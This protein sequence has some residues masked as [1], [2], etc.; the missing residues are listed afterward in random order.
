LEEEMAKEELIHER[1]MAE[2][3]QPIRIT[4]PH[5]SEDQEGDYAAKVEQLQ[6]MVISMTVQM[7]NIATLH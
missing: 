6:M 1:A 4:P 2:L 5:L 3:T 7:L